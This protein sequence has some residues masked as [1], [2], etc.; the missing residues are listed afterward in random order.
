MNTEATPTPTPAGRGLRG[1]FEVRWLTQLNEQPWVRRLRARLNPPKSDRI[2]EISLISFGNKT[3]AVGLEWKSI[4][5]AGPKAGRQI[6]SKR[7]EEHT[8]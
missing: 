4:I 7:S 1:L 6:A 2:A 3:L 5:A 8:S